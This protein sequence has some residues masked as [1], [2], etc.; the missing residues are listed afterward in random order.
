MPNDEHQPPGHG[1]RLNA[2]AAWVRE[3]RHGKS[4]PLPPT[5]AADPL[6]E[7]GHELNLLSDLITRRESELERLFQVVHTVERGILVEDVLDRIFVGFS[8]II[9]YDRIGCA[10]LSE[11]GANLTT[12]WARSNLGSMQITKG[13]SQP[14]AGSSLQDV[15]RTG[16]PRILNN[17]NA[18][19]AANPGSN[20][21]RRRGWQ[22]EPHVSSI[23]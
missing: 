20:S 3:L 10:F 11:G 15:F 8:G 22:V 2:Y 19:L 23:H 5:D 17:L 12:Y 16:Q 14:L 6:A 21:T 13:Y 9:P 4:V 1:D 7:L 18:Y